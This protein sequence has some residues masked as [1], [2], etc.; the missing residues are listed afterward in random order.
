MIGDLVND[1]NIDRVNLVTLNHDLLIERYLENISCY[2]IDGF[3]EPD[4]EF[5]YFN[6]KLYDNENEKVKLYKLHGS[7]NWYRIRDY[8]KEENTT[9]D[10]YAKLVGNNRWH[11]KNSKGKVLT[12]I[13]SYPIFLTGTYNKQSDYS[14]GIIRYVHL[15]FYECLYNCNIIIMSGYGWNDKGVN[16][17]LFEWIMT[18]KDRKLILLHE[19]PESIK[20]S[21]SAMWHRYDD[22]IKWGR[23]IPVKKWMSDTKLNDILEYLK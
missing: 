17:Y 12:T 2:F 9:Y 14:H 11:C 3:T 20:E 15:K 19:N 6:Q 4:G 22:F 8:V 1:K 23:I 10:F 13:E 7:L 16:T 21:K 18:S 5:C